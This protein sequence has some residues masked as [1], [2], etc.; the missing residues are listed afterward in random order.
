MSLK[1]IQCMDY[2]SYETIKPGDWDIPITAN[3]SYNVHTKHY[4]ITS[5]DEYNYVSPNEFIQHSDIDGCT[6]LI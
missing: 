1:L 6:K 4:G 3:P 5:E 2:Y